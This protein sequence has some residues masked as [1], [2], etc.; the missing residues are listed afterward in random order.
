MP[1][2]RE[3]EASCA[4]ACQNGT[5]R[6]ALRVATRELPFQ[7]ATVACSRWLQPPLH[8]HYKGMTVVAKHRHRPTYV[9]GMA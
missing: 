4:I 7:R 8:V 6:L 1:D 2:L 3:Y 5:T 9:R